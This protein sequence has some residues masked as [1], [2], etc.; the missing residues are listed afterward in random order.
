M[1]HLHA[2][3]LGDGLADLDEG[4]EGEEQ[5]AGLEDGRGDLAH[6]GDDEGGDEQADGGQGADPYPHGGGGPDVA[7]HRPEACEGA[8]A[9]RG[10]SL[11][12]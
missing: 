11:P 2:Q 1:A 3:A 6:R 9:L 12:N 4:S 5:G 8:A 10:H 7:G